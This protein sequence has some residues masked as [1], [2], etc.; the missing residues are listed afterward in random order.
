MELS[1]FEINFETLKPWNF[2]FGGLKWVAFRNLT[3]LIQVL[4]FKNAAY[5]M[6]NSADI[7]HSYFGLLYI[8][9]LYIN[10]FFFFFFFFFVLFFGVEAEAGMWWGSGGWDRH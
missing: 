4:H 10:V 6:A 9:I 1:N 8:S 2:V 3:D 5:D 7:W